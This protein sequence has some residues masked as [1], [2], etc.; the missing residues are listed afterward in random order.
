[1]SDIQAL[2]VGIDARGAVR[3]G[4]KYQKAIDGMT[5]KTKRAQK[6]LQGFG[7]TARGV[8]AAIGGALLIRKAITTIASFESTMAQ[9]KGVTSATT[10]DMKLMSDTARKLGATTQFSASQAAEGLLALSRAGFSVSE[11]N[12]AIAATLN[13]ATA[14]TIDLGRA[15]E[16]TSNTIRQFGLSASEAERV[17]DIFVNTANSANTTV[18]DLA[19]TMKFAGPVAGVLGISLEETAAAAGIL[20]NAGIQGSMGG[21]ALRMM[22]L[23][24]LDPSASAKKA[25][26]EMGVSMKDINPEVVGLAGA[27][28]ALSD[29]NISTTQSTAIFQKRFT[30]AGL[31]VANNIE[32]FNRLIEAN[33]TAAG[34]AKRNA[35]IIENTLTNAFKALKSAMS[36]ATLQLGDAGFLGGLKETIRFATDLVRV[37]S[38]MKTGAS[39]TFIDMQI[40]LNDALAFWRTFFAELSAGW[41]L[42]GLAAADMLLGIKN[43]FQ[44]TFSLIINFAKNFLDNIINDIVSGLGKLSVALSV[45]NKSASIKVFEVAKT[46]KEIGDVIGAVLEGQ[47][48]EIEPRTLE[49]DISKILTDVAAKTKEINEE[50]IGMNASL[51]EELLLR[52]KI[53]EKELAEESARASFGVFASDIADANKSVEGLKTGMEGV[54]DATKNVKDTVLDFTSAIS[55]AIGDLVTQTR[56]LRDVANSLANQFLRRGIEALVTKAFAPNTKTFGVLQSDINP[57]PETTLT[58]S[59]LFGGGTKGGTGGGDFIM[60][61]TTDSTSLEKKMQESPQFLVNMM[62]NADSAFSF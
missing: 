50:R 40:Q 24:L 51:K 58:E 11:S 52:Q 15:S 21:T 12:A 9:L 30:G 13:L 18:E 3:G 29:A 35:A 10:A 36:E 28:K 62:A 8:F 32:L 34:T 1:M 61:I 20:A 14:A 7:A 41:D 48:F 39:E 49:E 38:N 43:S 33:N 53:K 56:S 46:V 23:S 31:V 16:I 26:K 55:S 2:V 54:N 6:S 4:Q 44:G 60:N 37:L 59:I 5:R 47:K 42:V 45:V 22:F 57:L 19:Q 25:L 27:M 17:A